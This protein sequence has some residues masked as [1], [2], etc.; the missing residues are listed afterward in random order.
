ML[1]GTL[2]SIT[3]F[4]TTGSNDERPSNIIRIQRR[5]V[6]CSTLF[7]SWNTSR[8]AASDFGLA[9]ISSILPSSAILL[10]LIIATRL[11]I[12]STTLISCVMTTIVIP[13]R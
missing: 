7:E 6:K 13:I 8:F 10:S 1:T 3:I 11:H 4:D 9:K 5:P 12:S 2:H